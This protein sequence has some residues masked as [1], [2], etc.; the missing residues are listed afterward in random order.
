MCGQGASLRVFRGLTAAP[1]HPRART[2]AARRGKSRQQLLRPISFHLHNACL[3]DD[4]V[5]LAERILEPR[6]KHLE[7]LDKRFA[8]IFIEFVIL[9]PAFAPS[10]KGLD[11][12]SHIHLGDQ[13]G[14]FLNLPGM[15]RKAFGQRVE[16]DGRVFVGP[17]PGLKNRSAAGDQLGSSVQDPVIQIDVAVIDAPGTERLESLGGPTCRQR[18]RIGRIRFAAFEVVKQGTRVLLELR[19]VISRDSECRKSVGHA[20]VLVDGSLKSGKALIA[21]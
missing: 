16:F 3:P 17:I 14:E 1:G 10:C 4:S 15:K 8:L 20:D 19:D 6:T 11:H 7:F 18:G 21:V 5:A 2:P 9:A 13:R 12:G